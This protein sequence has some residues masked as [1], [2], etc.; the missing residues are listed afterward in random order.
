MRVLRFTFLLL[1]LTSSTVLGQQFYA[2]LY[3]PG[4]KATQLG[5]FDGD[6]LTDYIG[7]DALQSTFSVLYTNPNGSFD[8]RIYSRHSGQLAAGHLND[9]SILDVVFYDRE[10][11][12]LAVAYGDPGRTPQIMTL[13][14]DAFSADELRIT[15]ADRDGHND[16]LYW[17]IA[18]LHIFPGVGGGQF[19]GP[20]RISTSNIATR[21][22]EA[23]LDGDG[24]LEFL[25][26]HSNGRITVFDVR[27][28]ESVGYFTVQNL[29]LL[30]G[31]RSDGIATVDSNGD[32]AHEVLIAV[33]S[34]VW[35]YTDFLAEPTPSPTLVPFE[36]ERVTGI[37]V[38]DF[39][40][41]GIDDIIATVMVQNAG[42]VGVDNYT[43]LAVARGK[44]GGGFAPG[45]RLHTFV[46]R[47][48]SQPN[49]QNTL[50]LADVNRDGVEDLLVGFHGEETAWFPRS[51]DASFVL[52]RV[53]HDLNSTDIAD[54]VTADIDGD[55]F[56]ELVYVDND[57]GRIVIARS[58]AG[59]FETF[60]SFDDPAAAGIGGV[61]ASDDFDG[62]GRPEVLRYRYPDNLDVFD[63][64]TSTVIRS[65][66]PALPAERGR[67][68]FL[69]ISTGDFDA[70]GD[71]DALL[72]NQD[73]IRFP[74]FRNNGDA[75]FTKLEILFPGESKEIAKQVADI[76]GD[77]RVDMLLWRENP[78]DNPDVPDMWVI[79][80]SGKSIPTITASFT[81]EYMP[82]TAN[83]AD[84]DG[85][86]DADIVAFAYAS[87]DAPG[88]PKYVL[89]LLN[90]GDGA[91]SEPIVSVVDES[92]GEMFAAADIN[93]DGAIDLV[94]DNDVVLGDGEGG[95][96][97]VIQQLN[98]ARTSLRRGGAADFTRDGYPDILRVKNQ[99]LT[100]IPFAPSQLNTCV[101]DLSLDGVVDQQDLMLFLARWDTD[102]I[103]DFN[104][105]GASNAFDLSVLLAVWGSCAE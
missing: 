27:H 64:V 57:S 66:I 28:I 59:R 56:P 52:P 92:P 48:A 71:I 35:V 95:F 8:H 60:E 34:D 18:G 24:N 70:D 30:L 1:T 12:E 74:L 14:S 61:L 65:S 101:G 73:S 41:D 49:Y 83:F 62:D 47:G 23:D 89:C 10:K 51:A 36:G 94:A 86:G 58:S 17:N 84:A 46:S 44:L 45:E 80:D 85:D 93:N 5:D 25:G 38:L 78:S 29:T 9:D 68:E 75:S 88:D 90:L 16:I 13:L 31:S 11:D 99:R 19:T 6:G 32:D 15:D 37:R 54:F 4:V 98:V 69:R 91:F 50:H 97:Q 100:V 40:A 76:N 104:G 53:T 3:L 2:G 22:L 55:G 81:L 63:P 77:G 87:P 33:A 103:A 105:D 82:Y 39:D 96:P 72:L 21:V 42:V 43:D 7:G 67:L 79:T 20:F 26:H 102:W